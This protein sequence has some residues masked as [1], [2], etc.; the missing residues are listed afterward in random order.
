MDWIGLLGIPVTLLAAAMPLL[1]E[2]RRSQMLERDATVLVALPEGE[3]RDSFAAQ[4]EQHA[5][6]L[7][8]LRRRKALPWSW[9]RRLALVVGFVLILGGFTMLVADEIGPTKSNTQMAVEFLGSAV[10]TF[11]VLE[12][13]RRFAIWQTRRRNAG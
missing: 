5:S 13:W 6:E 2:W 4:F 12:L 11:A 1:G 10:G 8:E 7:V 3:I 9:R